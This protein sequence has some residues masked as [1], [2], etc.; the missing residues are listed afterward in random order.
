M[1][2]E[3]SSVRWTTEMATAEGFSGG[4][5]REAPAS[6]SVTTWDESRG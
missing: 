2:S 4:V 1:S 5:P 3:L 6:A